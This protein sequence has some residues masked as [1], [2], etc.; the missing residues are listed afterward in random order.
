MK[1]LL[2]ALLVLA[3]PAFAGGP[4]LKDNMKAL[5]ELFTPIRQ[6]VSDR[7]QNA[8]NADRAKQM[9]DLFRASLDLVPASVEALPPAQRAAALAEYKAMMQQMAANAEALR[10]AF[11]GGDNRAAADL[12]SKMN[13][14]KREGHDKFDK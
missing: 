6:T 9:G 8:A 13:L 11:A 2:I 14:G 12:V 4:T 7:G 1:S 3:A 10:A 5:G